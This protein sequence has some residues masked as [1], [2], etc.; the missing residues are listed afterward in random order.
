MTDAPEDYVEPLNL[1]FLRRLVTVLMIT[2][3]VGLVVLIGLFVTRFPKLDAQTMPFPAQIEL[4][5]GAT[6]TAITK[7]DGWYAVVTSQNQILIFDAATDKLRQ[8]VG[9][10][11]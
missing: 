7:G 4:P 9:I 6:V 10:N 3:I 2:M 11:P 5:E 1:K 8:T